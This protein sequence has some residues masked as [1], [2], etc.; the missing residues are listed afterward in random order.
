MEPKGLS[1]AWLRL[2]GVLYKFQTIFIYKENPTILVCRQ[3]HPNPWFHGHARAGRPLGDYYFSPDPRYFPSLKSNP[4][5][6]LQSFYVSVWSRWR[7]VFPGLNPQPGWIWYLIWLVPCAWRKKRVGW[8]TF[9]FSV[10]MLGYGSY[11]SVL[12]A[13]FGRPSQHTSQVQLSS[14]VPR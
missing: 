11:F 8:I 12:E 6:R 3:K 1:V 4:L 10:F 2:G 7:C 13:K 5:L 14:Y 9:T